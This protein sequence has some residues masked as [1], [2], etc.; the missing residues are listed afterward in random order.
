MRQVNAL[1]FALLVAALW[2]PALAR[3]DEKGDRRLPQV[4]N[5]AWKAECGSCHMLY[6]P[7]FLPERSWRKLMDGLD[8]HFGASAELDSAMQKDITQFLT[9][10]STDRGGTQYAKSIPTTATPLRITETAWFKREH[11]EVRAD[12]WKRAKIGSPSNCIACHQVAEQGDFSED[13]V[14]IPR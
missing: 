14:V 6:H 11:R 10:H 7:G 1:T 2:Q 3:A 12:V 5:A 4:S 8:K 9:K 13:K